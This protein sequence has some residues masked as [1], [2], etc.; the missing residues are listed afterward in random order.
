MT[1]K[2]KLTLVLLTL[3]AAAVLLAFGLIIGHEW[4][5]E[6][7]F[8]PQLGEELDMVDVSVNK[9]WVDE[10]DIDYPYHIEVAWQFEE[11]SMF[12]RP[13]DNHLKYEIG[14]CRDDYT[15]NFLNIY[16]DCWSGTFGAR[17]SIV[18]NQ[19]SGVFEERFSSRESVEHFKETVVNKELWVLPF[20]ESYKDESELL[21]DKKEYEELYGLN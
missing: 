4:Y 15:L 14:V 3:F 20:K 21:K 11:D 18:A 10:E 7:R 13:D 12:Y 2:Q 8:N 6:K 5:Q 17:G 16:K 19:L 1:D 9:I